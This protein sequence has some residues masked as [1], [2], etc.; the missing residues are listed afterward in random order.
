MSSGRPA[1]DCAALLAAAQ[2]LARDGHGL[3]EA[4]TDELES[5]IDYV[6]FGRKRGWAELE[7]GE[8]TELELRDLLIAHFDYECADRSGR[9]WEQ[10]PA[11]V[12]EA[13]ITAI[14][15]ALYGR[16]AGS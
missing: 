6:L 11:A 9:S 16:A 4:P 13:V 14:D 5:R 3:A 10:L 8:T 1:P 7:A 12:R 2:L 15:G